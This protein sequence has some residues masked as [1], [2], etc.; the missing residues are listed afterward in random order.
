MIRFTPTHLYYLINLKCNQK[1]SKCSHWKMKY[2]ENILRPELI[3]NCISDLNY[4]Q[5]F[6][7]V[8]GEPLI[9]KNTILDILKGIR[10]GKTRT[11]II[12]NGLEMTPQFI[13]EIKNYNIHVVVSV[14]TL[15]KEFWKF[16]RGDD[17]YDQVMYNLKSAIKELLPEQISIQSV[18][19]EETKMDI[20]VIAEFCKKNKIY[21]SVQDYLKEGFNGCWT[22]IKK[23]IN[24]GTSSEKCYA[25]GRNL[26]I[27]PNGDVFTCF[28]Q[29]LIGGCEMPLG[30]LKEDRIKK[31]LE[32]NYIN[33]VIELM[34]NCDM[35][36]KVLK[37]NIKEI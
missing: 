12:T 31:I 24:C 20:P 23:D 1:C 14:D 21:Y 27:M 18:L 33:K 5:E 29:N 9:Y 37:C 10:L 8:G 28:Q 32:N 7:I 2:E 22:A 36:C 11:T 15:E 25:V 4:P 34:E 3:V 6:C 16:V 26:S 19:S 35:P 13:S 17:S 30:N